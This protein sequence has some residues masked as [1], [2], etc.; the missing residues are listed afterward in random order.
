MS[1]LA[2][3]LLLAGCSSP[4]E[5]VDPREERW[6]TEDLPSATCAGDG[7]GVLEPGE[8]ASAG[9]L[10]L[11]ATFVV[12]G[13]PRDRP[14]DPWDL[15]PEVDA[16]DRLVDLGPRAV[17]D[18][19]FAG[20]FPDAGFT[21]LL[22]AAADRWGLYRLDD[23]GLWL[24]GLASGVEGDTA[25]QY[26][27][28]V[29]LVPLP[30]AAG[31]R[32]SVDAQAEGLAEGVEYPQDLGVD[33][34]VSLRHRWSLEATGAGEVV[35]PLGTLPALRVRTQVAAEA[36]NSAAGLIA[37]DLQRVDLY[38]AECL[39]LVGRVRSTVD[40]PDADW[41][42]STEILRLGLEAELRP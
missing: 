37:S 15:R 39:G 42:A 21:T 10:D 34:V 30:L 12:N 11:R 25:L 7:D 9:D 41:I 18:Q 1:R 35:V 5:A 29:L 2:L 40:E 22:D 32:W 14:T 27:P 16:E 13:A 31:D 6:G 8:L 23:D 19:W 24:L 3:L 28:P 4:L 26:A 33:G 17:A 36:H 20:R 38:L